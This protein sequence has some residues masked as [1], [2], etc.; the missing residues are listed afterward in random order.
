M[1]MFSKSVTVQTRDLKLD[2][3]NYLYNSIQSELS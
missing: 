2:E 3:T 1:V